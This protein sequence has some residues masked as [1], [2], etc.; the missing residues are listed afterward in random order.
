M[1]DYNY[2]YD[3]MGGASANDLLGGIAII[4]TIVSIITLLT[5]VLMLI[6]LWKVYTKAG[7]PGWASI[8]PIYNI[9]VL[10]E[11]TGL[12]VWYIALMFIPF[13]N[14]YAMFKIYIELAHK[15]GK[16]TGFG[17]GM[18]FLPIICL[19][20]LAFSKQKIDNNN[21]KITK[22][23]NLYQQNNRQNVQ[24]PFPTSENPLFAPPKIET[25][26]IANTNNINNQIIDND[27]NIK[28]QNKPI[29]MI[30][31]TKSVTQES[32]TFKYEFS[33]SKESNQEET[34]KPFDNFPKQEKEIRNTQIEQSN[35]NN[36]L[37][38]P[39]IYTNLNNSN[40]NN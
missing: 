32:N 13:A 40:N 19:P 15:F 21:D 14:I 12:P 11:I 36:N 39:P 3:Y 27:I 16:S 28:E 31:V 30:G 7:K 10:L 23:N 29:Q 8:I 9:I 18:I 37:F 25:N 35:S 34:E 22:K 38:K 4:T 6:S 24:T 1:Y 2:G 17:L 26:I 20:I 33:N 5:S